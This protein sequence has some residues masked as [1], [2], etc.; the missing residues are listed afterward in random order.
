[1]LAMMWPRSPLNATSHGRRTSSMSTSYCASKG[2]IT[3]STPSTMRMPPAVLL[4]ERRSPPFITESRSIVDEKLGEPRPLAPPPPPPPLL[5]LLS[6]GDDND[7]EEVGEEDD[8]GE[9]GGSAMAVK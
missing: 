3:S 8:D 1:M 6:D 4:L 7:E 9:A 5:L 2:A